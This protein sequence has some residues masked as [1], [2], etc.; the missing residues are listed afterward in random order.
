MGIPK[1]ITRVESLLHG[2][3]TDV[4]RCAGYQG[5]TKRLANN[6]NWRIAMQPGKR[7]RLTRLKSERILGR[8]VQLKASIRTKVEYLFRVVKRQFGFTKVRYLG[9]AKTLLRCIRC[10]LSPTF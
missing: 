5:V 10:L 8:M 2:W 6:T 9:L 3:K 7:R 1:K 4:F